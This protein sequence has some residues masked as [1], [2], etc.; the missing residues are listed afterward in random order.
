LV[1]KDVLYFQLL[2]E[3]SGPSM[4]RRS[5][6][7]SL[8]DLSK[9]LGVDDQ[10]VRK[11][12]KRFQNSGF[13]KKWSVILNPH[14]FDMEA[15]SIILETPKLGHRTK[16]QVLDQLMLIDGV[17]ILFTFLDGSG[18]RL[19]LL[20]KDQKDLD[21][22]VR[23]LSAVCKISRKPLMW[24][25]VYPTVNMRLKLTDW[26]LM[27]ML[28]QN[29]HASPSAMAAKIGVSARTV[30]RRLALLSENQAFFVDPVVDFKQI[31]GFLYMFIISYSSRKEKN[32]GDSLLFKS[33]EPIIFV[34]TT[35]EF[36]TVIAIICQNVSQANRI[37]TWLRHINGAKQV[38]SQIVEDRILV[39]DW[40]EGE[41]EHRIYG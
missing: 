31:A 28:L 36:Y 11:S 39:H 24:K 17:V 1:D 33:P 25:L 35:A 13:L 6:F 3:F 10:T 41:I 12:L 40:L 2:R 34:D 29:S 18:F 19:I 23:L 26:S 32:D 4:L 7:E 22:K 21:R 27:E 16:S 8:T 5:G 30:R 14:V 20:Y 9:K 15:E 37:S 38:V